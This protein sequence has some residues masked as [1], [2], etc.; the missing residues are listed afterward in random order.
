M[1]MR[2]SISQ[3]CCDHKDNAYMALYETVVK[4]II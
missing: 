2:F 1:N 3:N 4:V